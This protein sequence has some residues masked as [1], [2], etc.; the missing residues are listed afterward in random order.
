M[1]PLVL[2]A[3]V[4]F[5]GAVLGGGFYLARRYVRAVERRAGNESELVELRQRVAHL[6]DGLDDTRRDVERLE[7]AQEFM[8]RLL[9]GRPGSGDEG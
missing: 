8:N 5:W 2:V 4:A 6:E 1:F 3:A 7:S 9:A